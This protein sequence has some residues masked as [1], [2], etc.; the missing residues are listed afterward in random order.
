MTVIRSQCKDD[1]EYRAAL[2]DYFAG[3]ALA[4]IYR[5]LGANG[6][7]D[8]SDAAKASYHQADAMLAE[9]EK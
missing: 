8:H 1:A 2:R 4:G 7:H 3:I 6:I 9:R 5:E